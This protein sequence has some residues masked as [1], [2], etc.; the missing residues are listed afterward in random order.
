LACRT[1]S[2]AKSGWIWYAKYEAEN[3]YP[4]PTRRL[5]AGSTNKNP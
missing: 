5:A 4:L 1:V 2:T 3:N